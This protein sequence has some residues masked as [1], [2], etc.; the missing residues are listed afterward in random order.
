M[1]FK[2][3]HNIEYVGKTHKIV[4]SKDTDGWVFYSLKTGLFAF[5]MTATDSWM[6]DNYKLL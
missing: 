3:L 5:F 1:R 4:K 6:E 2:W